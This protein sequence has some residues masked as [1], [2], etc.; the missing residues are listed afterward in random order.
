[1]A[2]GLNS[3]PTILAFLEEFPVVYLTRNHEWQS[4]SELGQCPKHSIAMPSIA[5]MARRDMT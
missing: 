3:S 5:F 4:A 1:M 2:D